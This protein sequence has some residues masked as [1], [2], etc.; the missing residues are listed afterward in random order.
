MGDELGYLNDY[1]FS[2]D[3]DH[4]TDNRWL[5]RPR[6]NWEKADHRKVAGSIEHRIFQGL[7]TLIGAYKQAPQ[8]HSA[9]PAVVLKCGHP[10]IFAHLRLHLLGNVI[11]VYNQRVFS[12][13]DPIT[14][15]TVQA[16]DRLVHLAP[17]DRLWIVEAS[18]QQ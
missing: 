1:N 4:A 8:L 14:R 12:P 15:R 10:H 9:V 18:S 3:P 7:A 11:C 13:Y 6:M 2:D 5:H 17:Y 16:W